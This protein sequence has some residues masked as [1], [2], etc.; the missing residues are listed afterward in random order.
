ML[1]PERQPANKIEKKPEKRNRR[2]LALAAELSAS[3]AALL[4]GDRIMHHRGQ[5][6]TETTP[7]TAEPDKE[8]FQ[9]AAKKAEALRKI[10][11]AA[12]DSAPEANEPKPD[13]TLE[14]SRMGIDNEFMKHF[15]GEENFSMD[16]PVSGIDHRI[17]KRLQKDEK[18]K[19]EY[20]EA[21]ENLEFNYSDN[22]KEF[23]ITLP[24]DP[25]F[26]LSFWVDEETVVGATVYSVKYDRGSGEIFTYMRDTTTDPEGFNPERISGI[27]RQQV[28][29][30]L[31]NYLEYGRP[32]GVILEDITD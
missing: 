5:E 20:Y 28:Q 24:D 32:E 3:I 4:A 2:L 10:L 12:A 8:D 9:E 13:K 7:L 14:L 19:E 21:L 25:V 18:L 11:E 17:W 23:I 31:V 22:G 6:A 1:N 30:A 26:E 27:T 16:Q 15:S 29:T